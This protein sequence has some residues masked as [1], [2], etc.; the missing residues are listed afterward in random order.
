MRQASIIAIAAAVSAGATSAQYTN[1]H[2]PSWGEASHAQ[3]LS[4]AL[5]GTFSSATSKDYSNGSIYADRMKDSKDRYWAAGTYHAKMV[6]KEAA[7]TH[8]FGTV[9]GTYGGGHLNTYQ[10]FLNSTDIGSEAT[11]QM[12]ENFRWAI[13]TDNGNHHHSDT[14]FT[15]R[16]WDNSGYRDH[17]VS[18]KLLR[19][20]NLFGYALFFEDLKYCPDKDY[21]D[22]AV[23]LTLVPTPQAAMMGLTGLGG[24]GLLAGRRRRESM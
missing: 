3:I 5:G 24:L 10:A 21:N 22:V 11:I 13:E 9:E 15:S 6:A 23:I 14:L 17:M 18:Y 19:D 1:V 7:Y 4:S 12:D 8:T 16:D 2:S 20:G